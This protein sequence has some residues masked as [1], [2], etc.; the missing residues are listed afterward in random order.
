[1]LKPLKQLRDFDLFPQEISSQIKYFKQLHID[2]NVFLPSRNMNLQR[3][4]VW[5]EEQKRELILSIFIGRHVPHMAVIN[6]INPDDQNTDIHLIIDGKQR[7]S[8]IF[9][10]IDGKFSIFLEGKYWFFS[11]LPG[12]Y[13]RAITFFHFRYYVINEP[14]DNRITDDQIVAWFNFINFAGTPQDRAHMDKLR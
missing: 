12:E 3:D 8:T 14:W 1:M 6:R 9:D 13:Q 7:L 5:D 4:F 11:E 10:F 2:W